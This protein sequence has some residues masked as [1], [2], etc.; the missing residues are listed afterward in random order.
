MPES[1]ATPMLLLL[2]LHISQIY[3]SILEC[4]SNRFNS[5]LSIFFAQLYSKKYSYFSL[6]KSKKIYFID[7]LFHTF[8]YHCSTN[9][10]F[11]FSY[12]VN[13][14]PDFI[15][16][17]ANVIQSTGKQFDLCNYFLNSQ[18]HILGNLTGENNP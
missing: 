6:K 16:I 12:P 9:K 1:F 4:V 3:Y 14:L 7:S 13:L 15:S 17:F 10:L 5:N 8:L 18:Q 2:L 11:P